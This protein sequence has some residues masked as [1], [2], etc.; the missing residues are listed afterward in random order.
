MRW[1]WAWILTALL[2]NSDFTFLCKMNFSFILILCEMN[3]LSCLL[4]LVLKKH[5][6]YTFMSLTF[7]FIEE[8]KIWSSTLTCWYVKVICVAM[9]IIINQEMYTI[10]RPISRKMYWTHFSI[11]LKYLQKKYWYLFR[12]HLL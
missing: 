12:I 9:F 4:S 10:Y 3:W 7:N 2:N 6:I 1:V 5:Y 8:N 11:Q